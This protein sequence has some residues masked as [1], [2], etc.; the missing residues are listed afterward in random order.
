MW[1]C[2]R[3]FAL[4]GISRI[5]DRL[6]S[7]AR[8]YC[9]NGWQSTTRLPP[10]YSCTIIHQCKVWIAIGIF[11]KI[12]YSFAQSSWTGRSLCPLVMQSSFVTQCI[13]LRTRRG[14]SIP[15]KSWRHPIAQDYGGC[16]N[17][18]TS[19]CHS[20]T[21][22]SCHMDSIT[23][24][25]SSVAEI[26]RVMTQLARYE[27]RK[28]AFGCSC[29]RSSFEYALSPVLRVSRALGRCMIA[30]YIFRRDCQMRRKKPWQW[31]WG[32]LLLMGKCSNPS[33]G[34]AQ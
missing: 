31:G 29:R 23:L 19:H 2:E 6:R 33:Y 27:K 13:S 11:S 21:Q 16:K 17:R 8:D 30:L 20:F 3:L 10:R 4:A 34:L 14:G 1:Q 22:A 32:W 25:Q 5:S 18:V 15:S 26:R 12:H 9:H 24:Y 28:R 7:Q